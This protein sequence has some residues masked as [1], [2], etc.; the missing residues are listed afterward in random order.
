[1]PEYLAPGVYVEEISMGP[2]PI[3]GVSTSTA[4]FVGIAEKGPLDEPTLITNPGDFTRTFGGYMKNSY[5]AY[6]VDGFFRNGGKRC[7]VVRIADLD[8]ADKAKAMFLTVNQYSVSVEAASAGSTALFLCKL[9]GDHTSGAN[10]IQ[11]QTTTGLSKGSTIAIT[12][13]TDPPESFTL[14]AD[15]TGKTAILPGGA[16]LTSNYSTANS[17]VYVRWPTGSGE[18]TVKAATGFSKGSVILIQ[19]A[20]PAVAPVFLTLTGVRQAERKLTW[21][22]ADLTTDIEGAALVDLK[23]VEITLTLTAGTTISGSSI[24]K[25]DVNESALF[26]RLRRGDS[27]T[28]RQGTMVET[29]QIT[30]DPVADA[31]MD[32]SSPLTNSYSAAGTT[33]K[34]T[35]TPVAGLFNTQ[36]AA[37]IDTADPANPVVTLTDG[38]DGLQ[39]GDVVTLRDRADPTKMDQ[40]TIA[41]V[42]NNTTFVLQVPLPADAVLLNAD[43]DLIASL[44][45]NDDHVIVDSTEGLQKGDLVKIEA[46]AKAR[47]FKV[48]DIQGNRLILSGGPAWPGTPSSDLEAT[49]T[50]VQWVAT[51]VRSQEFRLVV[52]DSDGNVVEAF[53]K[54]SISD[55]SPR[56]FARDRV[57]NKTSTLIELLDARPSPGD[58]PTSPNDL[59]GLVTKPLQGG[60]DGIANIEASDY[61]GTTTASGD[62]TGIVALEAVDEVNIL[63]VPDIVMSF[64]GGNG[65]LSPDDVELL[66]LEM[67]AHC[68]K[69]KD[70]FAV[71]DSIRNQT[72]Q[73]VQA[74][75]NDN[76]DSKYAALYY[77]WI[78]VSDPIKA[79]D[80]PVRF[81]PPSGHM[82][83]IYARSDIE[84]GVHKAPANEV[85]RGVVELERKIT[86]GEQEI[87]N[88]DGINCIR[89]FP[90]RGI[91]VWGARCVTSDSEWK[92]VNVRRLFIFLEESLEEG[93]QWVVFEPNDEPLWARVRQSVTNFLTRVWRD[94]ALMGTTPEEA[95][96]V[97]CDRTTMTQDDIDNGRLIMLIGVA[98]VKPA[99]FVIIRIGQWVGGSEVEEL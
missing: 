64:G 10:T 85:V 70:R 87:L 54:L 39:T 67:I 72:V 44:Q 21:N 74:W 14:D 79:E 68:E 59:P 52:K 27:V 62:R 34:A 19:S 97:K 76:L 88:P 69:L 89:A 84:R 60:K 20:D 61:M 77:P 65:T 91:R 81:V 43:T 48:D 35:V 5:L 13:G 66:Q 38:V 42:T 99:E 82:A 55:D 9:E 16:T 25:A 58:A 95:F 51:S 36:L 18:G 93:T 96:F 86:K 11:L 56:Y 31:R 23:R 46:G 73:E 17:R 28:I 30:N 6:A 33:I 3:E 50:G 7:Y 78:E 49:I 24:N 90:G 94:G 29:R 40:V 12:N 45:A 15:P 26:D 53:D 83:G 1:M 71:L 80:S 41:S 47:V 2:K 22:A 57:V 63:C 4:A 37:D 98:P 92:Y 75:R 32:F 8:E